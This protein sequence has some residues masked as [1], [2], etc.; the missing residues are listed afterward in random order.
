MIISLCSNFSLISVAIVLQCF[1]GSV[2]HEDGAVRLVGGKDNNE[3]RVE[4]CSNG[5]WG[6]VCGSSWDS[7]D[8]TVVCRQLG[9]QSPGIKLGS[10]K[11]HKLYFCMSVDKP[12]AT[13]TVN[14]PISVTYP[15]FNAHFG[16]GTGPI[17]LNGVNCAG[18]EARLQEC[19]SYS[20]SSPYH[21]SH[22]SDI[23]VKCADPEHSG[24][25]F[26]GVCI[27]S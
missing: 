26:C 12:L 22:R 8:A 11:S 1:D 5:L 17:F 4:V 10:V 19:Q 21:C 24:Y 25:F 23:G 13:L 7:R 16:A 14:F 3:G 2:P 9:Y 20:Y 18:T 6:S 27:L 15:Y